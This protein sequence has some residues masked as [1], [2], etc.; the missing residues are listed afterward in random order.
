MAGV[1][2]VAPLHTM[3]QSMVSSVLGAAIAVVPKAMVLV[4]RRARSLVVPQ[5]TCFP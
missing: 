5:L 2:S 1:I 4:K 3:P